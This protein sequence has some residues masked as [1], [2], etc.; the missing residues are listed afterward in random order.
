MPLTVFRGPLAPVVRTAG[1]VGGGVARAFRE[2]VSRDPALHRLVEIGAAAGEGAAGTR[3][4]ALGERSP[5]VEPTTALLGRGRDLAGTQGVVGVGNDAGG[6]EA[7]G[8]HTTSITL[9][10]VGSLLLLAALL[11]EL[12]S[13][14]H[15]GGHRA[16]GRQQTGCRQAQR[17]DT[18]QT[19]HLS[20]WRLNPVSACREQYFGLIWRARCWLTAREA[21]ERRNLQ[22]TAAHRRW[23]KGRD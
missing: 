11:S 5:G 12:L 2:E 6:G 23:S 22:M 1:E 19:R 13:R 15:L 3:A 10:L 8:G 20:Y 18:G 9:G 7:T 4:A 14:G 17:S 21:M 16:G